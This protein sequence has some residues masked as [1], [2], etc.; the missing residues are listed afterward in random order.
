MKHKTSIPVGSKIVSLEDGTIYVSNQVEISNNIK[1]T[2]QFNLTI[3]NENFLLEKSKEKLVNMLVDLYYNKTFDTEIIDTP[4]KEKILANI[5]EVMNKKHACDW[6]YV[7]R[8]NYTENDGYI[9]RFVCKTCGLYKRI[10]ERTL[11]DATNQAIEESLDIEPS[12]PI[13]LNEDQQLETD[14]SR[15]SIY[16]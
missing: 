14:F 5:H 11:R 1:K 6:D 12:S 13:P 4:V 2:H 16:D 8:G 7:D 9:I 15:P 3:D 10:E